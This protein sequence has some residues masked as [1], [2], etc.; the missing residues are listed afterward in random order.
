[1]GKCRLTPVAV[2]EMTPPK[3]LFSAEDFSVADLYKHPMHKYA[4]LEDVEPEALAHRANA[5]HE[6]RCIRQV[7]AGIDKDVFEQVCDE[8]DKLWEE[9]ARLKSENVDL[10]Q[11]WQAKFPELVSVKKELDRLRDTLEWYG[12]LMNYVQWMTGH[13]PVIDDQGAQARAALEAGK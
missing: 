1:M 7:P 2:A 9:N 6:E 13:I 11:R 10:F 8:R 12:D 3:P 5:L 4:D